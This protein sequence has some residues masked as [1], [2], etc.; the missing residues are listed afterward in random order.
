MQTTSL[1]QLAL[2]IGTIAAILLSWLLIAGLQRMA[3]KRKWQKTTNMDQ[4]PAGKTPARMQIE[5]ARMRIKIAVGTMIVIP[6]VCGGI[7]AATLKLKRVSTND[8]ALIGT[9]IGVILLMV[10]ALVRWRSA[11]RCHQKMQWEHAAREMVEMAVRP[12][13]EKGHIVFDCFRIEEDFID[14][15]IV[16]PKGAFVLQILIHPVGER[17]DSR[18]DATVTY[19]GRTLFFPD[20]KEGSS[21][22]HAAAC[23]EKFSIWLSRQL[24]DP[25]AARA[26]IALPGWQIK[27]VSADGIS[28][29]NP[30]QL[31][32]LFQYIK[33]R[34]L[35]EGEVARI[36]QKVS[37][38]LNPS[39][40]EQ[41]ERI[42]SETTC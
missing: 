25:I 27:R 31:E 3:F 23:A 20:R 17:P 13:K 41:K 8:A 22:E 4:P 32:A 9:A 38:H 10:I 18:P 39:G 6:L 33:P 24:D 7:Y 14:Y 19:D 30:S 1:E 35:S 36:V 42:S 11:V 29:I 2:P 12:M 5:Y 34:P 28:V 26:I 15:L 40:K 16:G 37:Q 21:V